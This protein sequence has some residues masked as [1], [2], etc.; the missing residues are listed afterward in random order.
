MPITA[1]LLDMNGPVIPGMKTLDDFTIS[2]CSSGPRM[3]AQHRSRVIILE[4]QRLISLITPITKT[5][6]PS[7]MVL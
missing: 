5:L 1:I 6:R 3:S 2:N 4:S 7:S